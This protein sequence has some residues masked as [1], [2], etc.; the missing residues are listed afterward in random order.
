MFG[1]ERIRKRMNGYKEGMT[2]GEREVDAP[3]RRMAKSARRIS[4]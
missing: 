2:D 1:R 4:K 3:S